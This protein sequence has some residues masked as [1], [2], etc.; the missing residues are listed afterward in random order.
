MFIFVVLMR[1]LVQ[2]TSPAR[3][4]LFFLCILSCFSRISCNSDHFVDFLA[5]DESTI[6]PDHDV[7]HVSLK[8]SRDTLCMAQVGWTPLMIVTS[9]FIPLLDNWFITVRT[10]IPMAETLIDCVVFVATDMESWE[11]LL[12]RTN[13]E[14]Y[15]KWNMINKPFDTRYELIQYGDKQYFVLMLERLRLAKQLLL[16]NISVALIE[17]DQVLFKNPFKSINAFLNNFCCLIFLSL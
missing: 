14:R 12:L 1:T 5:L 9:D 11:Y 10:N 16:L 8:Q 13:V 7:V 3:I 4:V 2:Y 15:A 6:D 17:A